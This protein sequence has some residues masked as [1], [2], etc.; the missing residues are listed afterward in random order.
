M[1][2]RWLRG[3]PCPMQVTSHWKNNKLTQ[4][5]PLWW[6]RDVRGIQKG[7]VTQAQPETPNCEVTVATEP[8]FGSAR[9]Q[10]RGGAERMALLHHSIS[11]FLCNRSL[12]ARQPGLASL[13]QTWRR[14]TN[15]IHKSQERLDSESSAACS[16]MCKKNVDHFTLNSISDF[17][18]I[19][20]SS[21]EHC[22]SHIGS[23][24][25]LDK[26]ASC[27]SYTFKLNTQ[28]MVILWTT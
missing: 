8:S 11:L 15:K 12:A 27:L 21:A 20:F 28:N 9:T 5:D 23:I 19:I 13:Q 14:V 16:A 6:S 17:A 1:L 26:W 3:I 2:W 24:N 18:L 4:A 10:G 7:Q 25:T 22:A